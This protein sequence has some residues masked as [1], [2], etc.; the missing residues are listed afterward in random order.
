MSYT[1]IAMLLGVLAGILHFIGY[2]YYIKNEDIKPQP[3]TWFMFAY[4][5]AILK[6]QL[7]LIGT[8]S[9]YLLCVR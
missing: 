5:T 2:V 7:L 6:W 1:E 4:G 3:T 9:S 8:N